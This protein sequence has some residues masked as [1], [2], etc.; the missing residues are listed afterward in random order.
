MYMHILASTSCFTLLAPRVQQDYW[1]MREAKKTWLQRMSDMTNCRSDWA[2]L[3]W[4]IASVVCMLVEPSG[5]SHLC[6][7][8]AYPG[9]DL[10]AWHVRCGFNY[11][12]L[13]KMDCNNH[14]SWMFQGQTN[15][16][17]AHVWHKKLQKWL[18]SLLAKGNTIIIVTYSTTST[19][20]IITTYYLL[21]LPLLLL[22]RRLLL[23]LVL[24][25]LLAGQS[26]I[27]VWP[28]C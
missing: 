4:Q 22:L 24:L 3:T 13:L 21:L 19:T 23:V 16:A 20:N 28:S 15:T 5:R 6:R 27:L 7:K 9:R 12:C 10:S 1:W 18:R 25:Q 2:C 11:K 14:C 17:S 8:M 26:Y